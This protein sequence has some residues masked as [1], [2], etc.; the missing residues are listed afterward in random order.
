[1]LTSD[2]FVLSF[3]LCAF[4]QV[5][6]KGSSKSCSRVKLTRLWSMIS[7]IVAS[8]PAKDPET[9]STT[10]PTSTSLQADAV[11]ELFVSAVSQASFWEYPSVSYPPQIPFYRVS[12]GRW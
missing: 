9:K 7:T 1:M 2:S 4:F 11:T 6:P 10:L 8:L 12:C 3:L 5:P